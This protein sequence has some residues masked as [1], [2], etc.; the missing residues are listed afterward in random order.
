MYFELQA[1]FRVRYRPPVDRYSASHSV[2][3]RSVIPSIRFYLYYSLTAAQAVFI[4]RQ[5]LAY[6][7]LVLP[8]HL[9][10]PTLPLNSTFNLLIKKLIP[11]FYPELAYLLPSFKLFLI[12]A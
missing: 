3:Y 6:L 8:S 7:K 12:G 9:Y 4:H 11:I 2:R 1:V 10:Y 5:C